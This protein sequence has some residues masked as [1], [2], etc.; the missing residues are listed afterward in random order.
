MLDDLKR[1][2]DICDFVGFA[3]PNELNLSIITKELK[4]I[5]IRKGL[6]FFKE[7]GDVADFVIWQF[8]EFSPSPSGYQTERDFLAR[9]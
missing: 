8:H 7:L 3:I 2:P 5:L 4:A 1:H 9:L 6:A